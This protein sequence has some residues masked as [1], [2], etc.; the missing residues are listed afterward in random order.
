MDKKTRDSKVGWLKRNPE[1]RWLFDRI[2]LMALEAN[3]E[4]F[5]LEG[6]STLTGDR[7]YLEGDYFWR[8]PGIVHRSS[9][10]EGFTGLLFLEGKCAGDHSEH[11]SRRIRPD[12]EAGQCVTE[13]DWATAMGSRG[14]VRLN[15]R[16]VPWVRG[17]HWARTQGSTELL[18]VE[19]LSVKVLSHNYVTGAQTILLRLDPGY[20]QAG[21]LALDSRLCGF[22]LDGS[23]RVGD[24]AMR[25]G[26][27]IQSAPD[28]VVP[29]WTSESGA[30]L[31]VKLTGFLSASSPDA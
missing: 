15:T 31:F 17:E 27:W 18:D 1:L 24:E 10:A 9:T 28:E 6:D 14:W 25:D 4:C 26:S 22:V 29:A 16:N 30:T 12:D 5:Y 7:T 2:N 3:E 23:F 8:P 21:P 20:A 19:H 11:T 13:P